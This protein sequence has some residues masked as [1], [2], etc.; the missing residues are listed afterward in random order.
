VQLRC[1]LTTNLRSTIA[2]QSVYVNNIVPMLF[3]GCPEDSM[4]DLIR[5]VTSSGM[6]HYLQSNAQQNLFVVVQLLV[7]QTMV[8]YHGSYDSQMSAMWH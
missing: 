6:Q 7:V 2:I 3:Q 1:T 8:G 4:C 5:N